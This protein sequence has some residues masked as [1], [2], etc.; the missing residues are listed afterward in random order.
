M[1]ITCPR[2][3]QKINDNEKFCRV[4]YLKKNSKM[5]IHL[6]GRIQE[7]ERIKLLKKELVSFNKT[8]DNSISI[9]KKNNFSSS[10]RK[11]ID[12]IVSQKIEYVNKI[13]VLK[14]D[15]ESKEL[16]NLFYQKCQEFQS[17]RQNFQNRYAVWLQNKKKRIVKGIII[18]LILSL[19]AAGAGVFVLNYVGIIDVNATVAQYKAERE[20]KQE[21]KLEAKKNKEITEK[22]KQE[23][24]L[25]EKKL[26]E[27]ADNNLKKVKEHVSSVTVY[28]YKLGDIGPAGGI[29]FYD[30]GNY[31]NGWR[32]LECAQKNAGNGNWCSNPQSMPEQKSGLGDGE[33]NSYYIYA[34]LGKLT[35]AYKALSYSVNGYSDWYLGSAQEYKELVNYCKSRKM[36]KRLKKAGFDAING[37]LLSN[38]VFWTSEYSGSGKVYI[39]YGVKGL[40]GQV[41]EGK[42]DAGAYMVRPIRKF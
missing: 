19:C 32:Y 35:A 5:Y 37:G 10:I 8:L 9:C 1:P 17:N 22:L 18:T 20:L 14:N 36:K 13:S 16:T 12:Q 24:K 41:L 21:K 42:Y 7:R 38:V 39:V 34:E 25:E 6:E 26:K 2:C 23:K 15:L 27:A 4:C 30:K 11:K 3:S 40:T 28:D 31:S 33:F 29:I